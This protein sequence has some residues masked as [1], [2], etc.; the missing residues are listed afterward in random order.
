MGTYFKPLRRKLGVATLLMACEFVFEVAWLRSETFA[1][2]IT[3]R[4]DA[5]ISYEIASDRHGIS[6]IRK[7]DLLPEVSAVTIPNKAQFFTNS[8]ESFQ[9]H[10]LYQSRPDHRFDWR[11]QPDDDCAES[12]PDRSFTET[13]S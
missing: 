1:D 13:I 5:R 9:P 2:K 10:P 4:G 6:L 8:K 12:N 3:I 7:E 11:W